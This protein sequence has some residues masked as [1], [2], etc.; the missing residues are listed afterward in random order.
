MALNS[1]PDYLVAIYVAVPLTLVVVSVVSVCYCYRN[2]KLCFG[3]KQNEALLPTAPK[4]RFIV[5]LGRKRRRASFFGSKNG[6]F[7]AISPVNGTQPGDENFGTYIA[8]PIAHPDL[9]TTFP[10]GQV[11]VKQAQPENIKKSKKTRRKE[12][13]KDFNERSLHLGNVRDLRKSEGEIKKSLPRLKI[14]NQL[15]LS[16]ED[17][18][19]LSWKPTYRPST[20]QPQAFPDLVGTSDEERK[21]SR[22]S[23]RFNLT[24]TDKPQTD[25]LSPTHH[26][27]SYHTSDTDT[28]SSSM[29]KNDDLPPR[30]TSFDLQALRRTLPS[31]EPNSLQGI[32]SS[33]SEEDN[34]YRRPWSSASAGSVTTLNSLSTGREAMTPETPALTT[35]RRRSSMQMPID[36]NQIDPSLYQLQHFRHP[37]VDSDP[38]DN[39]SP[40]LHFTL[41]YN[42][43]ME[44]LHV[45][46]IQARNLPAQDFSGTT[47]PYCTVKLS[48]GYSARKSKVH[49]RTIHPEFEEMFTFGISPTALKEKTLEINLFHFDQFSRHEC[50]GTMEL[51]LKDVDFEMTPT[52]D[53]CKSFQPVV[54][55]ERL[56]GDVH[57]GDLMLAISYLRSAEKLTVAIQKARNLRLV[58]DK[59]TLPDA[60]VK[61]CLCK[62]TQRLKKKKTATVQT[63]CNPV[64]NQ[65]LTFNVACDVLQSPDVKI[66]CYVMHDL[67]LGANFKLGQF[68]LSSGSDD[69]DAREHFMEMMSQNTSKPIAR[70]H[71]LKVIPS[72][73]PSSENPPE[74]E[75]IP[76]YARRRSIAILE[77]LKPHSG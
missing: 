44:V 7:E 1:T 59:K 43:D 22:Q 66:L 60:Y 13:G 53:L 56:E 46:L 31:D 33:I 72:S 18:T 15:T 4:N 74:N 24:E 54:H 51:K 76:R 26:L 25:Y 57:C 23:I 38:G 42:K 70:W 63:T 36:L 5:D 48:P 20:P 62:G 41:D 52:F 3:K 45:K 39:E 11:Q 65:A 69:K 35:G 32:R 16:L 17:I 34:S 6:S 77:S 49:K 47:D 10:I 50:N 21:K 28:D 14:Q 58:D 8:S 27:S 30:R 68:E 9:V 2:R 29:L 71:R 75:S 61:V 73:T 55:H 67:K 19:D 37:S 64:F 40:Q 12:D